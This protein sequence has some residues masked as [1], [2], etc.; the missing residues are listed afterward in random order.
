M[1]IF[2]HAVLNLVRKPTKAIMILVI[3]ILV[4]SLVFTGIIIQNSISSSRVFIRTHLGAVVQYE[5]D[6]EKAMQD[7]IGEDE[8][9]KMQISR[10]T[11]IDIGKDARVRNTYLIENSYAMAQG[12]KSASQQGGIIVYETDI[13]GEKIR[14]DENEVVY[15]NLSGSENLIPIEFE[16]GKLT[17]SSGRYFSQEELENG[18]R[19]VII[20]EEFAAIN[21]LNLGDSISL[22]TYNMAKMD[23]TI[24]G[25]Y[26]GAAQFT[27]DNFFT[28]SAMIRE[29]NSFEPYP[30]EG[31]SAVYFMLND[32]LDVDSFIADSTEKLPSKYTKLAAN[33]NE[34]KNLTKP[35]DLMELITNIL[36]WVIFA[37]GAMIIIAVVTI[38]IRDRKFEIGLLLSTGQNKLK[39]AGQFIFEIALITIIAF[40]LSAGVSQLTSGYVGSWIAENQLTEEKTNPDSSQDIPYY[41][42]Y[43]RMTPELD[44]E[45]VAD[46]FDV[47]IDTGTLLNLF[48]ISMGIMVIAAGAPLFIILRYKPREALQD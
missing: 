30:M 22:E 28:T 10:E 2:K 38:F 23:C 29:I 13:S 45:S 7:Q 21:S 32:P 14:S 40:V 44:I 43:G 5:Q 12:L 27:E 15:L 26:S 16:I 47:S 34:Y 11:A 48:L 35:L 1:K 31:Y 33:N 39:I 3:M 41:Y 36:I 37:A 25:I 8:Y 9:A 42:D 46:E 20:S 6:W 18:D 24:V 17:L 19:V 4:F